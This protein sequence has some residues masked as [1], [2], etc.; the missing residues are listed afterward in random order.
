MKL[1]RAKLEELVNPIV[2]RCKEPMT[3]AIKDAKWK[4]E[5]INKVI[6]VGGPTRMPIV[7]KFVEGVLN[8]PPERGV[9]PMECVAMGAAIQAGVLAGEVSDLLLLDVTPLSLGV[10]TLGG[11]ATRIIE[12][13]TTIP[14][15]KSQIFTTAADN[16]ESVTVHV[17]QGERSMASDNVSLGMFNLTGIPPAPRGVPQI[18][19]TFDINA[20]GILD[21]TAKDKATSKEQ[22]ITITASTKLKEEEIDKMVDEA[23]KYSEKDKK[24]KEEV[25]IRN[26]ADSLIYTTQKTLKD[27]GDKLSSDQK[28]KLEKEMKELQEALS[29]DDI[30][31][32]KSKLDSLTTTLQQ[33]GTSIYQEAAKQQAPP[34]DE[35][36]PGEKKGE[37]VVDAEYETVDEEKK[38]EEK[39]G[40]EKK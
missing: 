4:V 31:K 19:V 25:E 6:L 38:N 10:E 22:K 16:Q 14:T 35:G 12:R 39:K 28:Q 17:L 21:V 33:A 20:D 7:Q 8:T 13:N 15:K 27:L 3:K 26:N 32:I 40:K 9:D 2:E 36:E 11:V 18:E 34:K 5:E 1:N 30:E 29:G 24:K 23:E 37:K